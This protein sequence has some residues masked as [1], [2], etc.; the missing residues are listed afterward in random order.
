MHH[1]G[2][3]WSDLTSLV[4]GGGRCEHRASKGGRSGRVDLRDSARPARNGRNLE[5]SVT[6]KRR[7][8]LG[9]LRYLPRT[10]VLDPP[11]PA[12]KASWPMFDGPGHGCAS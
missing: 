4:A 1:L 8:N 10:R 7:E 3:A 11:S 9:S 2:M 12:D 5:T 6:Q